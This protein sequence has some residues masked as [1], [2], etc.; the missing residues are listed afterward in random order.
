MVRGVIVIEGK[1]NRL[2]EEVNS[3][4]SNKGSRAFLHEILDRR[5]H[6]TR[7]RSSYLELFHTYDLRY[8]W[9]LESTIH[10]GSDLRPLTSDLRPLAH[11]SLPPGASCA[12]LDSKVGRERQSHR[13]RSLS[14]TLESHEL[15]SEDYL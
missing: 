2:K 8:S 11:A 10:L 12:E 1:E 13:Q 3:T 15:N 7:V 4:R 5:S 6:K 14:T 9:R